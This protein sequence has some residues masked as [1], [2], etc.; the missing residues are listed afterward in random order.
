VRN[1]GA[2]AEVGWGAGEGGSAWLKLKEEEEG[3]GE[4]VSVE[5]IRPTTMDADKNAR[6]ARHPRMADVWNKV[7]RRRSQHAA[8]RDARIGAP[9]AQRSGV[10]T[11]TIADSEGVTRYSYTQN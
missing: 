4:R 1:R 2:A 5:R 8:R 3:K 10:E 9:R 11:N 6:A 7:G